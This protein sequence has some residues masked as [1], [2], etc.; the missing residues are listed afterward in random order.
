MLLLLAAMHLFLVALSKTLLNLQSWKEQEQAGWS[1]EVRL[2]FY[3]W[4]QLS[5]VVTDR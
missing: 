5:A 4:T 3:E 2:C 1:S